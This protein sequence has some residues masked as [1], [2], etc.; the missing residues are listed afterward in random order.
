M[1]EA[2][3]IKGY[4]K[5]AY[6]SPSRFAQGR[7]RSWWVEKEKAEFLLAKHADRR[8]RPTPLQLALTREDSHFEKT[9]IGARWRR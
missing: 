2:I 5:A 8:L 3:V 9:Y 4:L 6:Y 1:I 7:L